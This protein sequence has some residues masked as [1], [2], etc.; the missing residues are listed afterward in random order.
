MNFAVKSNRVVLALS[1][2]GLFAAGC[3]SDGQ[4]D[5]RY[6]DV[7]KLEQPTTMADASGETCSGG[8]KGV[9]PETGTSEST[10]TQQAQ[11]ATSNETSTATALPATNPTTVPYSPTPAL[12]PST[13][14]QRSVHGL[15]RSHWSVISVSPD[16]GRTVHGPVYYQ[17]WTAQGSLSDLDAQPDTES[18]LNEALDGTKPGNLLSPLNAAELGVQPLGFGAD[19]VL[20]PLRLIMRPVW[21]DVTT[22]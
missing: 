18:K 2:L 4:A 22:P 13:P 17:P 20:L 8:C 12:A 6:D 16:D 19:T 9:E 21:T 14:E 11:T 10:A 15:D 1:V 3:A 5:G 7:L